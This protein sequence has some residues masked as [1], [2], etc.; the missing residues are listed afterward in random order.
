MSA[1]EMFDFKRVLGLGQHFIG[2]VFTVSVILN[3]ASAYAVEDGTGFYLLGQRS[4]QAAVLPPP[5]LFFQF[6]E[7]LYSGDTADSVSDC[8]ERP[9]GSRR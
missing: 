9:T 5:G 2:L 8:R 7:Y 6:E 4:N 1:I 3:A